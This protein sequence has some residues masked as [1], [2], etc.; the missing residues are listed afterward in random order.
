MPTDCPHFTKVTD[1]VEHINPVSGR[2]IHYGIRPWR[3]DDRFQDVLMSGF[4]RDFAHLGAA[5]KLFFTCARSDYVFEPT[6]NYLALTRR[7]VM[8]YVD[9]YE[10]GMIRDK[11]FEPYPYSVREIMRVGQEDGTKMRVWRHQREL[12]MEAK[13]GKLDDLI[14]DS[15]F[16]SRKQPNQR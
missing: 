9:R 10:A 14:S 7:E 6:D 12:E 2:S 15:V 16:G 1:L 8:F 3:C 4:Q 5:F 13:R 11:F